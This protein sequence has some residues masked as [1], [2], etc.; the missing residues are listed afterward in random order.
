MAIKN[1]H[2]AKTDNAVFKTS[3][4]ENVN[5]NKNRN[6]KHFI[7]IINES[8]TL[9]KIRC[10]MIASQKPFHQM[11]CMLLLYSIRPSTMNNTHTVQFECLP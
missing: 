1:L 3:R 2:K 6:I 9:Y 5:S 11:M 7:H 10:G 4:K 8:L